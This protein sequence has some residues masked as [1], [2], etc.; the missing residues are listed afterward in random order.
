MAVRSP[1]LYA[2]LHAFC[3]GAI[4]Y[5]AREVDAGAE[6]QFSFEGHG[7]SGGPTLYDY[8]PLVREFVDAR[9]DRIARLPDAR[10][11]LDELR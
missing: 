4:A 1:H 9:A 2:S 7:S 10:A 11:A 6:I 3:L 5:L 8:R